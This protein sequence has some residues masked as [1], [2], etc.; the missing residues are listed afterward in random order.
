M[1]SIPIQVD[2][3]KLIFKPLYII[4][5]KGLNESTYPKFSFD[6]NKKINQIYFAISSFN[7]LRIYEFNIS[8]KI[9]PIIHKYKFQLPI[10]NITLTKFKNS[11]FLLILHEN[12]FYILNNEKKLILYNNINILKPLIF[13]N[14]Q[15]QK[16]I[17][18]LS[19]L[20]NNKLILFNINNSKPIQNEYNLISNINFFEISNSQVYIAI[21]YLTSKFEIIQNFSF[22]K[23]YETNLNIGS[24]KAISWNLTDDILA[25][26]GQDDNILIFKFEN[27]QIIYLLEGHSSFINYLSFSIINE[28]NFLTLISVAE[29]NKIGIWEILINSNNKIQKSNFIDNS[30]R[31]IRFIKIIGNV[32]IWMDDKGTIIISIGK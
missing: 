29:D 9:Q 16:S 32:L 18:I 31:S 12:C 22:I 11:Y 8:Q 6:C 28:F 10:L 13:F 26:S 14:K 30:P 3:T 7:K 25:I 23:E 21:G 2:N 20:N 27:K 17:N 19:I 15:D 24:I 1:I 4:T 5:T